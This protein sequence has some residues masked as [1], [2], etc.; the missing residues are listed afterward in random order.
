MRETSRLRRWRRSRS[1]PIRISNPVRPKTIEAGSGTEA[2]VIITVPEV[3][4][5]ETG[6]SS[7]QLLSTT[8]N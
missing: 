8:L 3:L 4:V 2:A 5:N 1:K 7:L 6:D